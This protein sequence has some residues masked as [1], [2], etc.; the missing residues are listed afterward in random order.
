MDTKERI[1]KAKEAAQ[2]CQTV[3]NV[4]LMSNFVISILIAGPLQTILDSVKSLQTIIHLMLVNLAYPA[5][6]TLFFGLLMQVL[7]FQFYDFTDFY[8]RVLRLDEEGK[9]AFTAQFDIMGYDSF[10][11][12]LNFGTLCWLFFVTPLCWIVA[13]IVSRFNRH[14]FG[15]IGL[16]WNRRMFFNYWIGLFCDTY[17]YL[18]MCVA[19]NFRY[20]YFD[21]F[22]NRVNSTMAILIASILLALPLFIGVFYRRFQ[23]LKFKHVREFQ[24]RYGK[25]IEGLNFKRRG[26]WVLFY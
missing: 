25:G 5:T 24:S 18:G 20:F 22:G 11:L 15:W 9:Q 1:F 23:K 26:N 19:L 6:S 4:V 21:N 2:T 16:I 7:T 10:Y 13:S 8:S 3:L 14:A 17:L 12:I